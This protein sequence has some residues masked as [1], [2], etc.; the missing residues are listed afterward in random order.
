MQETWVQSL[1]Q[2]DPLEKKIATY[3]SILAWE[4]PWTD[5]PG[6]LQSRVRHDLVT[7]QQQHSWKGGLTPDCVSPV[8][9]AFAAE[10]DPPSTPNLTVAAEQCP[11][12]EDVPDDGAPPWVAAGDSASWPS[13][14]PGLG[15]KVRSSGYQFSPE[16][17]ALLHPQAPQATGGQQVC[18]SVMPAADVFLCCPKKA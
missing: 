18:R 14:R 8:C 1:G 2:E 10:P 11:G 5:K 3:S 12:M 6:G 4:I 16:P 7:K 9:L 15:M 17:A 13:C